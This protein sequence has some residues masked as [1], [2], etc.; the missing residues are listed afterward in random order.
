[1]TRAK[2][3]SKIL[4]DADISGT[5]D[6]TGET[7]LATHLNLGDGDIIKLGA[8]AD[9]TIQHDGSDSIITDAGTGRLKI[10]GSRV[11]INKSDGSEGMAAFIEDAQVILYHNNAVMFQT[12]SSGVDISGTIEAD[13]KVTIAYEAGSSDWELESTSG[14]D[15]TISRNGSQKLLIDGSTS[16]VG[17]GTSSPSSFNQ[18]AD[19]LVVGTTSGENGI[20][21]A[22]GTGNSGRF[23]FSD[24]TTSS[25]SAFVG[26]MEYSHGSDALHFYTAGSQRMSIQSNGRVNIGV[27]NSTDTGFRFFAP[28][29][30]S[31]KVAEFA[32]SDGT[33]CHLPIGSTAFTASSDETL[34]ENITEFN[35]QTSYDDIKKMRAVT[36]NYK[37]WTLNGINYQDDKKRIGFIAQDWVTNYPEIIDKD[38]NDKLCMKYTETIPVLLSALQKAQEKIEAMEARITALEGA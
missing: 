31:S 7:T 23:V 10:Q 13:D 26:A 24:N 16:N 20:T 25:A 28:S 5:L 32:R 37:D 19:N 9:L 33:G 21:I 35:K 18:Y 15:F 12:T 1:M 36:F 17:I 6:V 22:S 4:T 11:D 14:D 30:Q 2:D 38:E 34:K 3:I 29:G 27:S 8:S